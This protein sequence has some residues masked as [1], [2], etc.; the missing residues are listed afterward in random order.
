[1]ARGGDGECWVGRWGTGLAILA[2]Y[3]RTYRGVA[4]PR[5]QSRHPVCESVVVNVAGPA[6]DCCTMLR[7]YEVLMGAGVLNV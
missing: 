1:M 3:T 6:Q 5:R 7:F 4:S 2:V